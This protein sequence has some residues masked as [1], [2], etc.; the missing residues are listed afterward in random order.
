MSFDEVKERTSSV[1]GES[2]DGG[3]FDEMIT[4]YTQR[5]K[6]ATDLLVSSLAESHSKPFRNYGS[7]AQFTTVGDTPVDGKLLAYS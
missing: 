1:M 2:E 6:A 5:R 4:A 7:R 3:V